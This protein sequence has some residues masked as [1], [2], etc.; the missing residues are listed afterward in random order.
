AKRL[1]ESNVYESFLF[2]M[3]A[4]ILV[5]ATGI[6]LLAGG[7]LLLLNRY[8][9]IA[10]MLLFLLLIP[11]TVSVQLQ[12]WSTS[13]PLFKNIA[14]AGALLFFINNNFEPLKKKHYETQS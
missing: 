12:G 8:T 14:I 5:T 1:M 4:G 9:R 11:I 13:G 10:A 3:D 7:L 2:F 6:G